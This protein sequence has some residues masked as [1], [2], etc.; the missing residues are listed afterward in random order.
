MIP[1][2][3]EREIILSPN[4]QALK[5][6][7]LMLV[8]SCS[9][10]IKAQSTL[11]SFKLFR[12]SFS[13][14]EEY[15]RKGKLDKA[16][17]CYE[18]LSKRFPTYIKSYIRLAELY[19]LKKDKTKIIKYANKAID[20]NPNEAYSPLTYLCNKMNS[21]HDDDIALLIMNR[22]S[23]S[24][25]ENSKKTRVEENRL[26]YT[27]KSSINKLPVPGV[28]LKNI[29]D[30]INTFENECLP[31]LSLDGRTL[32]FT[33]R[34]GGN[35]DFFISEK[36]TNGIWSK[37]KNLGY[38]PNT[39]MPEGAAMLS[40]DGY[41][42]FYTRCDMPSPDGIVGG[43]CDLVFSYREDSAWSSPQYFG[44]TINTTG[45]EGQPCISSDNKD[46]YFVS[47]REGG[48]GGLDI[49][50]SRFENN[51]WSKPIN[52]GP[53]INTARNETSPFI[54]PDNETLYFASDGHPGLGKTDLFLSRRN[55]NGTWKIPINMGAP[56]NTEDFDGSIVVNARGTHGY[57]ASD[58]SDTKGGLDIFQFDIYPAIEPVPTL[59]VKGFLLDKYYQSRIYERPI[60][61]TYT[62]NNTTVGEQMSNEGDA[63]YAQALQMGKNYLI[64]VIEDGYRPYY[65]LLKLNTDSL[66]DNLRIDI[67]LKQPGLKDTL[68][69]EVLRTD[70][71]GIEFDSTSSTVLDSILSKWP[72]WTED[73][74]TILIFLKGYYYSGDTITDTLFTSRV[75]ACQKKMDLL[76]ERLKKQGIQCEIIMQQMD[77][78]IYND[79]EEWF[80]RIEIKV[81]E[82]Y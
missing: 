27:L 74:A 50:V 43:G 37:A 18:D 64:S 77:M 25:V 55:K 42:L 12:N 19:Y 46:L 78:M 4:R 67:K 22:L 16:I 44:F 82:Y 6:T 20:L 58:R 53:S 51:Y 61:F 79:E 36:D 76:T 1:S 47:N 60:Y 41:Y 69:S 45:Y 31:T 59:C 38:P 13:S 75:T 73:S 15:L 14:C 66:P 63:S 49:W 72:Q 26:R 8:F 68:F 71:T 24:E 10:Q 7:F 40:A 56:I 57:L 23:V 9:L 35:E 70:S 54:H 33:R 39:S 81:V 11:D 52:L 17:D 32:V 62:F 29:G 80:K 48:Y 34:T 2:L 65:K 5:I 21:N 3:Q 28:D 30:S